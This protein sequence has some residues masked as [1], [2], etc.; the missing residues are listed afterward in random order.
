MTGDHASHP[1]PAGDVTGDRTGDPADASPHPP[2]EPH[3][4]AS[5]VER[6]V[7]S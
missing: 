7:T 2:R 3:R 1:E 4:T 5:N 6:V